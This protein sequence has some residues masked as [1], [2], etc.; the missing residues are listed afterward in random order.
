MKKIIA[1]I[2]CLSIVSTFLYGA[3]STETK[4]APNVPEGYTAEFEDGK[5][6]DEMEGSKYWNYCPSIMVEGDKAHI[7]YC[8]NPASNVSGDHIA[9]RDGIKID[10]KWY[11]GPKS[12]V[13]TPAGPGKWDAIGNCDPSVIRGEFEYQDENYNYLMAYLGG[14]GVGSV[15]YGCSF[16]FAVA[17]EPQGPWTKVYNDELVHTYYECYENP[18][19]SNILWGCGQPSII[20]V[21][22]KGKVLVFYTQNFDPDW[23][24]V[25]ERWDLSDL[26]NPVMDFSVRLRADGLLRRTGT[27]DAITNADFM[28][29]P[30]R[31]VIYVGTDVHPFGLAYKDGPAYP[32]NI[33]NIARVG[34]VDMT[35]DGELGDTFLELDGKVSWVEMF[36]LSESNTGSKRNSNLSFFRDPYGWMLDQNVLNVSYTASSTS[37]FPDWQLIYTWRI[38]RYTYNLSDF[39]ANKT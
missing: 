39:I 32:E 33:P 23:G 1:F 4:A 19:A 15:N 17:K 3:A 24:Q 38:H 12:L 30:I 13:G 14:D 6:F 26:D 27:E 10:G 28:Y 8:S 36:Q 5:L 18:E 25:V 9:Y 20:S 37:D 11:W 35:E 16:G 22:K 31:Q 34:Y 7:W 21:D 2:I 29:D